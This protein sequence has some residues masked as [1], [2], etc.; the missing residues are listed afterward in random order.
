MKILITGRNSFLASR[1]LYFFNQKKY[2][3]FTTSRKKVS[4]KNNFNLDL[5]KKINL[6]KN[7]DLVI[8]CASNHPETFSNKSKKLCLKKI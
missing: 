3:V 1:L 8:H 7:F 2:E 6:K 4:K 5:T